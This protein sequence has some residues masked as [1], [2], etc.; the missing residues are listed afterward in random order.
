[1]KLISSVPRACF[2]LQVAEWGAENIRA[3]DPSVDRTCVAA[4]S[5]GANARA[6]GQHWLARTRRRAAV[7]VLASAVAALGTA[8]AFATLR[9]KQVPVHRSKVAEAKQ[10]KHR[11]APDAKRSAAARQSERNR[12]AHMIVPSIPLPIARPAAA[13]L[14]PD[15][16]ATKQAIELVR[17]G[18]PSEATALATSIGDPVAQKLVEWTLL[19]HPES[20]VRFER[21]TAFIRANPNWP[22][23]PL[24]RRRAEARLWQ[25]RRDAATVR[26][27]FGEEQPTSPLGRLA[28][29]RMLKAEGDQAGAA[30]EV[31][32]VWRSAELSAELE[33]ALLDEFRDE[34]T[35][36]DHAARMDW[37]ISAKDFGAAMR[38]AK[39]LGVDEMAIVKACEAAEAD[40]TKARSLLDAVPSE[41]RRDM[42]FALCRLHW[43]VRHNEF[44]AAALLVLAA[45]PEDLGRQDTDEW[46]RERRLLARGLIDL[47]D[48]ETAYRVVREA[49]L[50]ANPYYRAEFHFMAGWIAL[51]F[52][53]DPAAALKHFAHV[54]EGSADPIVRARA[55]YWRGRAAEAAGQFEE[56]RAQYEAAA[57]YPTAYY[58]QLAR[59]LLHAADILYA[60]GERDLV[61]SFVTDL[62]KESSDAAALAALGQLTAH[63][64]DARAMLLVG[65]TALARGLA[66]DRYAFPD[67]G[68]PPYNPIGSELDP[69]VVYS[70][71]RTES[72]FDQ[73]DKSPAKA[74]GLM[75]VTPE[76]GRDTAKRFGVAYDW[77]GLVSDPVYN[78]QM[79]AAEVAAL[80]K[81]YRGSYIMT[82]AGYNAG[83]GRVKQWVAQHGDPRDPKVDAVDWVERSPLA[84]TRNY[85]QRVMENLQVYRARFGAGIATV[86]PNL[87]RAATVESRA[88]PALVDQIPQ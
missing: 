25:D 36:A 86:E 16:A 29:A 42:G 10:H 38:T 54:D 65:K 51:R 17:Q 22:S 69:C 26:R 5:G 15:L 35:R 59:E 72:A 20:E 3:S 82:F 40:S 39:R 61:A 87:H 70:V 41:A 78:T 75:Q 81:E 83:R 49:A 64:D 44:A 57:R 21:Y 55:A 77:N 32:A 13:S 4:L 14:P 8:D 48:S 2:S 47:G 19:R 45:S 76:A 63:Y 12:A 33:A 27:F 37:R 58:G 60:I 80:L 50:P 56:M 62:A 11:S 34:L 71:V 7:W 1:M 6:A 66:M 30:R 84:E 52:L 43:L 79:G 9:H 73:R 85:V 23:I 74:V 68:V 18:K 67:I 24:L 31:R 28:F 88:E 53:D 46:W